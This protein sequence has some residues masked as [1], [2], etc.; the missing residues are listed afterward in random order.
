[1]AILP[2]VEYSAEA[3]SF[4]AARAPSTAVFTFGLPA[5]YAISVRASGPTSI[6]LPS[7][8][9]DF[10]HE[11]F[12]SVFRKSKGGVGPVYP[13]CVSPCDGC[14]DAWSPSSYVYQECV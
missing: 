14:F 8:R 7:Y 2:I 9:G 11:Y 1:A 13:G 3:G 12:S 6:A 5:A 4:N 10:T